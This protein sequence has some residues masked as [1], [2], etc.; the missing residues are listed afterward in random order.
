[1]AAPQSSEVPD[2]GAVNGQLYDLDV[3][4]Y[5]KR[6][7][8]AQSAGA[9]VSAPLQD[10]RR[11]AAMA[12]ENLA[13]LDASVE[14][15]AI[16]LAPRTEESARPVAI[17]AKPSLFGLQAPPTNAQLIDCERRTLA[18][19]DG[20]IKR[21]DLLQRFPGLVPFE[22]TLRNP[23][24]GEPYHLAEQL[25]RKAWID[26][27]MQNGVP[28]GVVQRVDGINLAIV[29]GP[30]LFDTEPNFAEAEFAAWRGAI[31]AL[32]YIPATTAIAALQRAAAK[33]F[34]TSL[35]PNHEGWNYARQGYRAEEL[36]KAVIWALE[37]LPG[38]AGLPTLSDLCARAYPQPLR[39]SLREAIKRV[40][41]GEAERSAL[42]SG[43]YAAPQMRRRS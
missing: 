35:R 36:G 17:T 21:I 9:N 12:H 25:F 7:A 28:D 4:G 13:V 10:L 34:A 22:Y 42:P 19:L 38:K 43:F 23:S 20:L 11:L 8:R 31:W 33:C 29:D 27:R 30:Y 32:S 5:A 15:D 18:V 39:E 1:M 37:K 14:E 3:V 40:E 16:P 26:A 41:S 2:W 6:I 24:K